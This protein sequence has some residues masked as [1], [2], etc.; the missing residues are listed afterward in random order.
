MVHAPAKDAAARLLHLLS[1]LQS[2]PDWTG[3]QL[4]DRL[5]V[6][7]RTVRRDIERLRDLGYP[8][9]ATPGVAGGYRMRAGTSLPPLLLGDDEAVAVAIGLS[10]V[11]GTSSGLEESASRALAK[12]ERLLP[13]R[14]RHRLAALRASTVRLA[15]PEEDV[16]PEALAVIAAACRDRERLRF[17]YRDATGTASVRTAEPHRLVCTG[18]RWYLVARD[19]GRD[20]W[21]TF[22]VDRI[23]APHRTGARFTPHDPPDAAAFVS[24]AVSNGPYAFS[25]RVRLHVPV[26]VAVRKVPPTTGVLEADGEA[27][28]LLTTGADSLDLIAAHLALTGFDFDVLDPPELAERV[29]A[30]ARRLERAGSRHR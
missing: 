30:M 15:V 23:A 17:D 2:R 29:R 21:R 12:L 3:A 10:A 24:A 19:V 28:C 14:L 25:A 27:A 20:A 1:L 18:R 6:T 11:G 8:V 4:A 26:G 5:G 22:R 13:A 16:D 9:G 7:P